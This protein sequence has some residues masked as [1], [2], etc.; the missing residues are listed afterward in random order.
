[1][2]HEILGGAALVFSNVV[3]LK[4][5]CSLPKESSIIFSVMATAC[6]ITI[7]LSFFVKGISTVVLQLFAVGVLE[8]LQT[9]WRTHLRKYVLHLISFRLSN[10]NL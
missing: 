10:I 2:N 6:S 8:V 7:M 4:V 9:I 3:L 1:M 5:Y